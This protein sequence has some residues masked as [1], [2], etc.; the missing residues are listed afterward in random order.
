MPSGKGRIVPPGDLQGLFPPSHPT[1][2]NVRH[3]GSSSAAH[4]P[5]GQMP[6]P[7]NLLLRSLIPHLVLRGGHPE[8]PLFATTPKAPPWQVWPQDLPPFRRHG[9]VCC[10]IGTGR[11]PRANSSGSPGKQHPHHLPPP[12]TALMFVCEPPGQHGL[13]RPPDRSP[14][15]TTPPWG[16]PA[17]SSCAPPP[18]DPC[19]AA[20][21]C[22]DVIIIIIAHLC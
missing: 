5:R 8:T 17:L 19:P 7:G 18:P 1:S 4:T 3:R 20:L 11:G 13:D 22:A 6:R 15:A 2:G 10:S 9:C 14:T 12:S 16:H 21:I